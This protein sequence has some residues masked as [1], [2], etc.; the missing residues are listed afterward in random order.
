MVTEDL[1]GRWKRLPRA[2]FR[3]TGP[4]R[5]RYLNGQVS[6]DVTGA[7]ERE[8]VAAC[9]C[10]AK[11]KVEAL[12]WIQADQESLIVDGQM[13]QREFLSARLEK[14]LIADDCEIIDVS[15]ELVLHHILDDESGGV[16]ACRLGPSMPAGYDLWSAAGG[17]EPAAGEELTEEEWELLEMSGVVPRFPGEI[18]GEAFPAE[19][20]LDSWAVSFK[21]GCYL[22]QEVVSRMRSAGKVRRK[23]GLV[24][25]EN[26]LFKGEIILDDEKNPG[27][28]TRDS[29]NLDEKK[30]L[31]LAT[32][33]TKRA[34]D[35]ALGNQRV[36][37]RME[38]GLI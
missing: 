12:V 11:G 7:L 30:N 19:L 6:N 10:N 14:Y 15:D 34:L 21:K 24:V 38:V 4:D 31:A 17:S 23:L 37:K 20:S 27:T 1:T 8:A 33:D 35:L 5:I 36:V 9:V 18:D 32:F 16:R 22:G 29:R 28:I 2:V 26:P 3:V 13:D 25:S